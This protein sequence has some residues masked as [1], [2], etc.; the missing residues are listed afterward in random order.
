MY[1]IPEGRRCICIGIDRCQL[2]SCRKEVST[3]FLKERGV[4]LLPVGRRCLLS[5]CRK[6]VS[7][8]PLQEGGVS[9]PPQEGGVS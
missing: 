4:Y 7:P 6:E 1:F 8:V 5:S 9:C 2:T 3:Y